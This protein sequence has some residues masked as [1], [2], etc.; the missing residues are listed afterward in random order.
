M[1]GANILVFKPSRK[2]NRVVAGRRVVVSRRG[3]EAEAHILV[4]LWVGCRKSLADVGRYGI[5]SRYEAA[6]EV[7]TR[8]A[9]V[10][11]AAP[12]VSP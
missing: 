5:V 7:C 2:G 9:V 12:A 11:A 8:A 6:T 10:A 3:V 4:A 1:C